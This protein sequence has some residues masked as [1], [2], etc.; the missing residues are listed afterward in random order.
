M[1][2]TQPGI[3]APVPRLARYMEFSLL[4]DADPR[5]ALAQ[6]QSMVDGK[7]IVVGIGYNPEKS[8]LFGFEEREQMVRPLLEQVQSPAD[9]QTQSRVSRGQVVREVRRRG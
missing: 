1:D 2:T 5:P 9:A 3:L 4:P 6:L 8:S 7:E